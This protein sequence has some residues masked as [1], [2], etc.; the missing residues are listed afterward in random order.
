D[1][2]ADPVDHH[3]S[4]PLH[5]A[6]P[7]HQ[8]RRPG[9]RFVDTGAA[10]LPAGHPAAEPRH[11]GRDRHDPRDPRGDAVT[12]RQPRDEGAMMKRRRTAP[13]IVSIVLLTAAAIAFAF[14]FYFMLV[15]AFQE[16]PTNSPDEL[17]PTGGWTVDNFVAIDS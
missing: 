10:H 14:P 4:E 12:G 16:N 11:R 6:V 3:G 17:L 1:A 8:R 2:R 9:R 5:R 13:R 15:G 7:A